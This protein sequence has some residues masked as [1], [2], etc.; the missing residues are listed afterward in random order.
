MSIDDY[1]KTARFSLTDD[2]RNFISKH[3]SEL[4][5]S[6]DVLEDINTENVN[7]MYT[8][9]D[10]KN[11]FREDT[12]VKFESR[13]TLLSSAPEQYGGYFQVPKAID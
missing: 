7:P 4:K 2:E 1:A 12:A 10:V 8:V 11:I 9:L 5:L 3:A 6:F 13:E